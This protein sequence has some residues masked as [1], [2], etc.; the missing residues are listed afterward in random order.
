[1][2]LQK[3][4][5]M[6]RQE[7][8]LPCKPGLK[9]TGP[10]LFVAAALDFESRCADLKGPAQLDN[11]RNELERVIA[12]LELSV[13]INPA[14]IARHKRLSEEV[15]SSLFSRS[16]LDYKLTCSACRCTVEC[17]EPG[18]EDQQASR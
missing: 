1:M 3:W 18:E 7:C 9:L 8:R 13:G 5:V 14:I 10:H 2:K 11:L 6:H 4:R 15:S 17:W 12:D 16:R